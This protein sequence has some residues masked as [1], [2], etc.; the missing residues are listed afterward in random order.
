MLPIK[1]IGKILFKGQITEE[2]VHSGNDNNANN[3]AKKGFELFH[4]DEGGSKYV[5]KTIFSYYNT[6]LVLVAEDFLP[7]A[8]IPDIPTPPPNC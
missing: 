6:S 4:G 3:K 7:E 5:S 1:E 2:E 8:F